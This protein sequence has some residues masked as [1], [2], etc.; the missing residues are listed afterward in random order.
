MASPTFPILVGGLLLGA[1]TGFFGLKLTRF[2]T[3]AEGHF[4]T[5]D[6]RIGVA[7]SL[8]LAG[9]L[10]YRF[11]IKHD[12]F[13]MGGHTPPAQSPL[14]FFLIGLTFGYYV[15]YYAGLF[16]HTRDKKIPRA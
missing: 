16:L 8:L 15:V 2:E 14:T 1:V 6:T 11:L 5:P 3:T 10:I 9:R 12:A 4:Y 7:I 13:D